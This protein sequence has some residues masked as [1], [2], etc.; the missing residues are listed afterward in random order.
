MSTQPRV[1]P[2]TTMQTI[3]GISD[4]RGEACKSAVD[5]KSFL[6]EHLS[7]EYAELIN[8]GNGEALYYDFVNLHFEC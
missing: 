8:A 5:W 2:V 4:R 6:Q 7:N 3:P 1:G